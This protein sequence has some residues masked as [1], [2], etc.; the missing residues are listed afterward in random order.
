MNAALDEVNVE[1]SS[2]SSEPLSLALDR[3]F[4]TIHCREV[5]N[6]PERGKPADVAVSRLLLTVAIVGLHKLIVVLGNFF[7]ICGEL[8]SLGVLLVPFPVVLVELELLIVPD[9]TL[10]RRVRAE[11]VEVVPD[12]V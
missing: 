1:V 11:A 7:V 10:G 4:T 3:G 5:N 12:T 9:V 6:G 8:F 2:E